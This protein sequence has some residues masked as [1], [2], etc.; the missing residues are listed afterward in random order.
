MSWPKPS[1]RTAELIR[2]CVNRILEDSEGILEAVNEA[3]IPDEVAGVGSDPVLL[4]N[5]RRVNEATVLQWAEAN[6]REPGCEVPPYSVVVAGN[7]PSTKTMPGQNWSPSL[8]CAVI[9]K[10]VDAGTR[11]KTSVNELLRT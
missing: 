7:R 5:Y 11:S 1:E 2:R 3:S 8:Y 10:Q 9:V 4:R 6:L